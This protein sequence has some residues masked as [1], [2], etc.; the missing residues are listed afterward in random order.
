MK[1]T[2]KLYWLAII[3]VSFSFFFLRF[4]QYT[5]S[6]NFAM[7]QG[8]HLIES[9]SIIDNKN[10][11][12]IGPSSSKTYQNRQFFTGPTY[13]YILATLGVMTSWNPLSLNA[14][15]VIID[16]AFLLWFTLWLRRKF[17][18]VVSITCFIIFALSKYFIFHHTFFWNPHFLF[19]LSI[20]AVIFLDNFN[21]TNYKKWLYLFSFVFGTAFSF[22][23]TAVFWIIPTLIIIFKKIKKLSF[24]DYILN[25]LF[26][27]LGDLPFFIFELRH[28]FYNIKTAYLA[29]LHPQESGLTSHYFVFPLIMFLIFLVGSIISKSKNKIFLCTAM[30]TVFIILN[31]QYKT[32]TPPFLYKDQ[33]AV[34]NYIKNDNCL[35]K[36]NISQTL[37]GD[38]RAYNLR[39]LLSRV[40]CQP[41]QVETYPNSQI[42]YLVSK[43]DRPFESETIWEVTSGNKLSVLKKIEISQHINIYKLGR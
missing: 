34:V 19:P 23:Y 5:E 30:L 4:N 10:L 13:Y 6:F 27:I 22:H 37:T 3:L 31:I 18:D 1:F 9:K 26:F 28:G 21:K 8:V 41:N 39:F 25:L 36:F 35:G 24:K 33:L 38:S 12:L 20:C 7:D 40:N 14:I 15:L 43:T 32:S 29:F 2:A 11:T 16:F 17:G 42:V